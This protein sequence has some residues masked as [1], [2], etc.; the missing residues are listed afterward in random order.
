[1]QMRAMLLFVQIV[2]IMRIVCRSLSKKCDNI[3]EYPLQY[4]AR[5]TTKIVP[6]YTIRKIVI[7][8]EREK[9][10]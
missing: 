10:I 5:T 7:T 3:L 1:M 4:I 6:G 9:I 2:K 8:K